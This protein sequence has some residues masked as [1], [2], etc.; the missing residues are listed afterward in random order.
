MRRLLMRWKETVREDEPTATSSRK[1]D[2][3]RHKREGS[4][5]VRVSIRLT[6]GKKLV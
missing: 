2:R 4:Q 3:F 1:K 5:R 6:N